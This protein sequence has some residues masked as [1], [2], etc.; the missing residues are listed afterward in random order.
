MISF[1]NPIILLFI[2]GGCGIVAA[3]WLTTKLAE[4]VSEF[5]TTIS[6]IEKGHYES[7]FSDDDDS[8]DF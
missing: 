1:I 7:N 2:V 3:V 8:I 4:V 5:Y 6:N